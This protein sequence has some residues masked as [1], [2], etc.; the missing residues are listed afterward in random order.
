[1]PARS[2][3]RN[4]L[5]AG[6]LA[7]LTAASA[8]SAAILTYKVTSTPVLN[9]AMAPHG[10]WTNSAI[11][12]GACSNFF[13]FQDGTT[14]TV[15]TDSG[16]GT[17]SGTALNPQGK[18]AT[19]NLTLGGFIET[20]FGTAYVYKKEGGPA[21]D[22]AT[23]TPDIDFFTTGSGTIVIDGVSYTLNG[24]DPFTSNTL[25]EFGGED[26]IGANAKN[27]DFGG[28]AWI[29]ALDAR[30]ASLPHWDLNFN[31]E[32]VNIPEPGMLGL[33]GLGLLGI[34]AARRRKA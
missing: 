27:N 6:A 25:F 13:D 16:T 31:I 29:N 21:Y 14:F 23:D 18:L 33:L 15:D 10:L 9:C 2:T 3:L 34:G 12:G 22:P 1:M 8:A 28:S 7:G 11:G 17:F 30:G 32:L 20:T 4:I 19:I 5:A 26:G 24:A